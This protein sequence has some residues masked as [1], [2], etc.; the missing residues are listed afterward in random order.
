MKG[1]CFNHG[2]KLVVKNSLFVVSSIVLIAVIIVQH[3]E[4]ERYKSTTNNQHTPLSCH[5]DSYNPLNKND[6][7]QALSQSEIGNVSNAP[8]ELEISISPTCNQVTAARLDERVSEQF[9]QKYRALLQKLSQE[10][11]ENALSKV[12]QLLAIEIV[13]EIVSSEP[14]A[15]QPFN[16]E[17]HALLGDENYELLKGFQKFGDE[18]YSFLDTFINRLDQRGTT[19][20]EAYQRDELTLLLVSAKSNGLADI[21]GSI[22]QTIA[23]EALIRGQDLDD[24]LS[25]E[26][27]LVARQELLVNRIMEQA[28]D[29]L[30]EEQFARF[31]AQPEWDLLGENALIF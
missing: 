25:T 4:I 14:A 13:N 24:F 19:G 29:I 28:R 5:S 12:K 10:L 2:G 16:P 26:A 17:L 6:N 11:T 3:F 8:S 27:S 30:S 7:H 20:L 18:S 23:D 21:Y 9:N 31:T 22:D 1:D 15:D